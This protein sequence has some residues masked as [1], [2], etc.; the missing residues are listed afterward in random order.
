MDR[1]DPHNPARDAAKKILEALTAWKTRQS[2]EDVLLE[3]RRQGLAFDTYQLDGRL[4][5]VRG[6]LES[7]RER[8]KLI[9]VTP[10]DIVCCFLITESFKY[11]HAQVGELP[12][13]PVVKINYLALLIQDFFNVV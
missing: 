2:D 3:E 6:C 4:M 13:E 8:L 7:F 5:A 12:P 10:L 11:D 1:N 9:P